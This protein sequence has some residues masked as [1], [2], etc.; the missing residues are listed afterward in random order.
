MQEKCKAILSWELSSHDPIYHSQISLTD[1]FMLSMSKSET[2]KFDLQ[3]ISIFLFNSSDKF[4]SEYIRD[5][6][7]YLYCHLF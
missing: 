1:V 7:K 5:T 4:T 3:D 2:R 6:T